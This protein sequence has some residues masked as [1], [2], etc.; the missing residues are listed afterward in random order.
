MSTDKRVCFLEPFF[1]HCFIAVIFNSALVKGYLENMY[2]SYNGLFPMNENHLLLIQVKLCVSLDVTDIKY[3]LR[4][5][6]VC[7]K[8]TSYPLLL[9]N[10]LNSLN[11]ISYLYML[12]CVEVSLSLP[13]Q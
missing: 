9:Q 8:T 4:G 3:D 11:I 2:N 7:H 12:V 5:L 1:K 10:H 6:N 13:H